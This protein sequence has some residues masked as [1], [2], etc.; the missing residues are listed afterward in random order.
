MK[1]LSN[2]SRL[3]HKSHI[4]GFS[5]Q[6]SHL[7]CKNTRELVEKEMAT[8][9]E[10]NVRHTQAHIHVPVTWL[11]ELAFATEQTT[12]KLS[13][14]KPPPFKQTMILRFVQAVLLVWAEFSHSPA[15]NWLTWRLGDL[16]RPYA[17]V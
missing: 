7:T 9:W 3:P 15:V 12:L 16:G 4:C 10:N 6:Y 11:Y 1:T 17:R 5:N 14:L 13:D 8:L 2:Q